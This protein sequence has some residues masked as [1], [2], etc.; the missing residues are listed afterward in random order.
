MRV[1]ITPGT[2][3]YTFFANGIVLKG[4]RLK[5]LREGYRD[6]QY[7]VRKHL[8]VNQWGENECSFSY[9]I[10]F[11]HHEEAVQFKLAYLC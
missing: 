3:A 10:I 7:D 5:L 1:H 2:R 4:A 11:P 9:F 6:L 8:H